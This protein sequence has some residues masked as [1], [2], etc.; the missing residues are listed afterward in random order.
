MQ[1]HD[2]SQAPLHTKNE[3]PPGSWPRQRGRC[4]LSL[5]ARLRGS[6]IFP[7][8]CWGSSH[9][10]R[11]QLLAVHPMVYLKTIFT[12][13]IT[14][15]NAC[16]SNFNVVIHWN[17]QIQ[18]TCWQQ[19]KLSTKEKTHNEKINWRPAYRWKKQ[20]GRTTLCSFLVPAYI[21]GLLACWERTC[22]Q[23]P[24][25]LPPMPASSA[26]QSGRIPL[27][28]WACNKMQIPKYCQMQDSTKYLQQ[29]FKHL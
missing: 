2:I 1:T 24:S 21:W 26:K 10:E 28:Q 3:L 12:L 19:W 18:N 20:K 17:I 22:F 6:W 11:T 14:Q 7:R 9:T 4:G 29:A 25:C 16:Y 15:E 13:V 23:A 8:D 5:C 27:P